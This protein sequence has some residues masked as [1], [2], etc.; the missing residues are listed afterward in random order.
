ML[1][2]LFWRISK[3]Q[4]QDLR[5]IEGSTCGEFQELIWESISIRKC[6]PGGGA[7]GRPSR[8]AVGLDMHSGVISTLHLLIE[9]SL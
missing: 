5:E 1:I 9:S 6:H 7:G 2:P 8:A 4:C 3:Y